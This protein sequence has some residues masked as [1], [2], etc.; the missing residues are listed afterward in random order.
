MSNSALLA[1]LL[2]GLLKPLALPAELRKVLTLP[3][4]LSEGLGYAFWKGKPFPASGLLPLPA[5]AEGPKR[6]LVILLMLARVRVRFCAR[7]DSKIHS[8]FAVE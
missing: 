6:C 4:A 8:S 7:R 3:A 2:T 5:G 1:K